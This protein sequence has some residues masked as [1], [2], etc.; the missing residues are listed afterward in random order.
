MP[1]HMSYKKPKDVS[2]VQMAQFIDKHAYDENKTPLMEQ[3]LFEYMYHLFYMLACKKRYF[4]QIEDYDNF[5]KY[6][7]TR[8]Y[9]RYCSPRQFI[10]D[11]NLEDGD[12][13]KKLEKIRSCLNYIKL[14]IYGAKVTYQKENYRE[15]IN[16]EVEDSFDPIAYSHRM[17]TIVQQDYYMGMEEDIVT[18]ISKIGHKLD[19]IIN[20]T[21]YKSDELTVKNL[22]I[23]CLLTFL[24]SV[25]LNNTAARRLKRKI[26]NK[27]L[28]SD[29]MI[30]KLY[31]KEKEN[32][33]ILWH[34]DDSMKDYVQLLVNKVK[35]LICSRL[36]DTQQSYE[37]T[38]NV[39]EAIL[40]TAFDAYE[41]ED[42]NE[43][44]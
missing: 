32:S 17:A 10:D 14:I 5:A 9:M 36:K 31:T 41:G 7:A 24:N 2:Y 37:L 29:D 1:M 33:V 15:V 16:P 12:K 18:E 35:N 43:E 4:V 39:M 26:N 19:S 38:D 20:E 34:L 3:T 44:N 27:K 8:L 21:P 11:E 42:R 22:K 25:T 30:D 6:G 13:S 40:M 23:S 28:I